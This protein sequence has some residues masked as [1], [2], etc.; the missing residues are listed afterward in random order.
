MAS[1]EKCPHCSYDARGNTGTTCPECGGD[2]RDT[3]RPDIVRLFIGVT[4]V[5]WVPVVAS[6][7]FAMGGWQHHSAAIAL[8]FLTFPAA[9]F[10]TFAIVL[11]AARRAQDERRTRGWV[12]AVI[13]LVSTWAAVAMAGVIIDIAGLLDA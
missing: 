6:I 12:T 7:P 8:L 1:V 13:F 3:R 9:I 2:T 5:C 4:N 10:A 11:G